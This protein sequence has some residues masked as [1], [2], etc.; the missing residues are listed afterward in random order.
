MAHVALACI[1]SEADFCCAAAIFAFSLFKPSGSVEIERLFSEVVRIV[2]GVVEL[3]DVCNEVCFD[4]L[5]IMRVSTADRQDLVEVVRGY[6][7]QKAT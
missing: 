5:Y 4:D 1:F 2:C 6:D 3:E 7:E